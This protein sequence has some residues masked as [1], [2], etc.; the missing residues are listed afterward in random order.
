MRNR[1]GE[2]LTILLVV[3]A[4]LF[5]LGINPINY[6]KEASR[7]NTE[8]KSAKSME[9]IK[10][11]V[12]YGPVNN[13]KVAYQDIERTSDTKDV[14]IH[15]QTLGQKIAGWIAGLSGGAIILILIAVFVLGISP[16]VIMGWIKGGWK[17][18]FKNTVAGIKNIKDTT[19]ICRKCG[20]PVTI[21][22]KAHA[23][24]FIEQKQDEK[25]KVKV[26]EIKKGLHA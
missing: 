6:F 20:D 9:R 11:P 17:S 26:D 1:K 24:V 25:D 7:P 14:F 13:P 2:T 5:A 4:G 8:T 16:T 15:K 18:A 12:F 10:T 21:D 22:T 19:V 3:F 23:L